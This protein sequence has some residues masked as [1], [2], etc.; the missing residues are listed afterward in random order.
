MTFY[1]G[2]IAEPG[3]MEQREKRTASHKNHLKKK[4]N[5]SKISDLNFTISNVNMLLIFEVLEINALSK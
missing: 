5:N 1:E 3:R 2:E 4:F